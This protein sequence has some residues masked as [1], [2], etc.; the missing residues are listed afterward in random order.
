[1]YLRQAHNRSIIYCAEPARRPAPR[2]APPAAARRRRPPPRR[3]RAAA[4]TAGAT[5]TR[6][7]GGIWPAAIDA[8]L[9]R[10]AWMPGGLDNVL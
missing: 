8:A 7:A 6:T 1:V 2:R 10:H 5:T 3:R 9:L 4:R